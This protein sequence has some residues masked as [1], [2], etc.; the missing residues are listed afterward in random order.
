MELNKRKFL[1]AHVPENNQE[2][3]D[4]VLA[5]LAKLSENDIERL[6]Q[7][8]MEVSKGGPYFY[9]SKISER[10]GNFSAHIATGNTFLR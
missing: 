8:F 6:Y 10:D 2:Q 9:I 7:Y 4:I 5:A 1:E 3:K